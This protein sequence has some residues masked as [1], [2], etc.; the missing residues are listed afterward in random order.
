MYSKPEDFGQLIC[1]LH[2]ITTQM[3]NLARKDILSRYELE[4]RDWL[5]LAGLVEL[6]KAAQKELTGPTR[7]DKVAINRAVSRLAH[8]GLLTF[9]KNTRDGRS[10]LIELSDKGQ[11]IYLSAATEIA[12]LERDILAHFSPEEAAQFKYLITKLKGAVVDTECRNFRSEM[13]C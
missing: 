3:L 11:D 2:G 10:H 1:G 12:A 7:L 13:A 5:V 9:S 4:M 6:G 8:L